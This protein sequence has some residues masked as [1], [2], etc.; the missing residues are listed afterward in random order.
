MSAITGIFYRDGRE[1]DE[2]QIKRMNDRLSHRGPDG[3]AVWCEGPVGLGHQMLHTTPESLHEVLPYEE[4]GLVITA[5][6]RIDN[7]KELSEK[8]DIEDAEEVSDS[9]YILK[10][11]Q[12]WGEKCPEELLGDFAFAIWDKNKEQLFCARDHMGIKQFYYYQTDD[13]FYFATEMKSLFT[14]PEIPHK[15]NEFKLALFLMINTFDKLYTFYD[16][17]LRL[18]PAHSLK[19]DQNRIKIM[20]FW[21]LD[22]DHKLIMDSEDDYFKAFHEIFEE[23][24]KCRLRSVFQIG[25]E[26]SGGI[27]SSSVVCMAKKVL[28]ER[29]IVIQNLNTFSYVFN[30]FPQVDERY[31]IEKIV[32]NEGIKSNFVFGDNISLLEDIE[33]ILW[34]QEQP[35]YTPNMSI[36]WNLRKLMKNKQVRI[37]LSGDGGDEVVSLGNDYLKE[38]SQKRKWIKLIKE[39]IKLSKHIE[40][41]FFNNFLIFFIYPIIPKWI[42]KV[43]SKELD[44][45]KKDG[46]IILND[47][48]A[49]ENGGQEFLKSLKWKNFEKSKSAKNHQY[50]ILSSDQYVLEMNDKLNS[51]FDIEPRYPYYDKRLIEFCYSIPSEEMFK[52]GWDRFLQRMAMKDILPKEIQWRST[53]TNFNPVYEKKLQSHIEIIEI[54]LSDRNNFVNKIFNMKKIEKIYEDFKNGKKSNDSFSLW[55]LILIN[56]WLNFLKA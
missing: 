17:I 14:I 28:N 45:F 1:V 9:Y 41:N 3:S 52:F 29:E 42:K 12:K 56:S 2:K 5:D 40:N 37:L 6:A 30:D 19:I 22:P 32:N 11:Y 8:L 48:L 31:F 51:A 20:E 50:L 16:E 25:F 44:M 33:E 49:N 39:I 35:F 47:N 4:D 38:L 21:K 26:L 36:I 23:A 13:V 43:F 15:L 24:V 46:N 7:R 18:I 10:A 53:K 34:F 54:L 55:L 27:D